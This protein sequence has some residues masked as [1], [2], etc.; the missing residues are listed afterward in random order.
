M[1]APTTQI[2]IPQKKAAT[3]N[4]MF[5]GHSSKQKKKRKKKK[6]KKN[7][8]AIHFF[9]EHL[10]CT[11]ETLSIIFLFCCYLPSHLPSLR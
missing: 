4:S 6:K 2:N 1:Y 8:S 7:L 10:K 5:L 3:N 9:F 11:N